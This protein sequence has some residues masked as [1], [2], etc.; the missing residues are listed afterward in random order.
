[1]QTSVER[2]R[3]G[4]A[5]LG[6]VRLE[7]L[8]SDLLLSQPRPELLLS[9][10]LL[11]D[12]LQVP[13]RQVLLGLVGDNGCE[14][15]ERELVRVLGD[16]LVGAGVGFRLKKETEQEEREG[17]VGEPRVCERERTSGERGTNA[18]A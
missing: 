14:Q 9:V 18:P 12:E 13:R 7:P 3:G 1:M 10:L 15:V 6:E 11:Q 17:Q 16:A 5:H 4:G 8:E 2:G